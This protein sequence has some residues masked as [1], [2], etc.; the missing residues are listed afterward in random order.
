MKEQFTAEPFH[1][2]PPKLDAE[3]F[4]N[5]HVKVLTLEIAPP[6]DATLLS[7]VQFIAVT[8]FAPLFHKAAP[9]PPYLA[10]PF[11]NI[12]FLNVTSALL[13]IWKI[14]IRLLASIL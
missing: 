5:E 8:F 1:I 12:I 4:L 10:C 3:L 6:Y 9:N 7:N 2:A 11:A 14:L 13:V